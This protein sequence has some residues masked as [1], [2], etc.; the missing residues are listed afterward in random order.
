MQSIKVHKREEPNTHIKTQAEK[1]CESDLRK[2]C[3]IAKYDTSTHEELIKIMRTQLQYEI[4]GELK[5][6]SLNNKKDKKEILESK[7]LMKMLT[8]SHDS[9]M[10]ISI[11]SR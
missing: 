7:N 4:D 11:Y 10:K 3:A 9:G 1:A 6:K 2:L 8:F 5:M